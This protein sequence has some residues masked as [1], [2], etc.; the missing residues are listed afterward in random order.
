MVSTASRVIGLASLLATQ[1]SGFTY[2]KPIDGSAEASNQ[3]AR[4]EHGLQDRQVGEIAVPAFIIGSL[5]IGLGEAIYLTTRKVMKDIRDSHKNP[6]CQGSGSWSG[7]QPIEETAIA[8]C[9]GKSAV[10]PNGID[11]NQRDGNDQTFPVAS[12]TNTQTKQT[13]SIRNEEGM[14][15]VLSYTVNLA[16][17]TTSATSQDCINAFTWIV[18][19]HSGDACQ[20]ANRDTRGGG[21][22]FPDGTIYSVDPTCIDAQCGKNV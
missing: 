10:N 3:V 18:G 21:Y 9:A 19:T 11:F 5:A 6:W 13:V 2:A 17:G 4:A 22:K 20:G 1:F 12:Y 7:I 16:P 14:E 8:I 15:Q